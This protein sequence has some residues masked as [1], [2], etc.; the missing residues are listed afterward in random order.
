MRDVGGG[1][2]GGG[3]DTRP[4][5]L[6]S[7]WRRVIHRPPPAAPSRA[8]C[9]RAGTTAGGE[10]LRKPPVRRCGRQLRAISADCTPQGDTWT[11]VVL[12]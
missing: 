3:T 7:P 6:R 12:I 2:G 9:R 1:G 10:S 8:V 4:N 5:Q 11:N